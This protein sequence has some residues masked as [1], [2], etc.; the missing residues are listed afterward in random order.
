MSLKI[1][2]IDVDLA[3]DSVKEQ[4]EKES[5]LSSVLKTALE[6]LLLPGGCPRIAIVARARLI[7]PFGVDQSILGQSPGYTSFLLFLA[8]TL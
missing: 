2:N 7:S 6:V 3:I 8:S 1:E 4:L 5:N